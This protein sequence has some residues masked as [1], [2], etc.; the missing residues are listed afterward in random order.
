MKQIQHC[1]TLVSLVMQ[2]LK[3]GWFSSMDS[4]LDDSIPSLHFQKKKQWHT[5]SSKILRQCRAAWPFLWL[6]GLKCVEVE[7]FSQRKVWQFPPKALRFFISFFASVVPQRLL[8]YTIYT[9]KSR[10][11]SDH[12]SKS[13]LCTAHRAVLYGKSYCEGNWIYC[14]DTKQ[15]Q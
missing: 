7:E 5:C 4:I 9:Y 13:K 1:S 3:P 10:I 14:Q 2:S 8:I 6:P 15:A 12:P 11:S